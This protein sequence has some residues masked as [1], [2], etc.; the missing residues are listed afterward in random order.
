M[1]ANEVTIINKK[2]KKAQ[3]KAT[4][5]KTDENLLSKGYAYAIKGSTDNSNPKEKNNK[6]TAFSAEINVMMSNV[7]S[8]L[9]DIGKQLNR[10]EIHFQDLEYDMDRMRNRNNLEE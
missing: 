1:N 6:F 7:S 8:S 2:E 10:Q 9:E 5:L 4:R 3:A